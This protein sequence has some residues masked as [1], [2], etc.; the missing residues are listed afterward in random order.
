M[1]ATA[2]VLVVRRYPGK[3]VGTVAVIADVLVV[4]RYPGKGRRYRGSNAR[5][6]SSVEVPW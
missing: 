5:C 4:R 3:V 1:V 6:S 2:G